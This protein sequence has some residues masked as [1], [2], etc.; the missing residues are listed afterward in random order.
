MDNVPLVSE[1]DPLWSKPCLAYN[2]HAE[3]EPN[4]QASLAQVQDTALP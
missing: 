1:E 3:I 2:L 4:C